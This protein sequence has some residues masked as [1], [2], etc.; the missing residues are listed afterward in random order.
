MRCRRASLLLTLV[1]TPP[2]CAQTAP[3]HL[4]QTRIPP[5][6]QTAPQTMSQNSPRSSYP[7]SAQCVSS[8]NAQ[9]AQPTYIAARQIIVTPQASGSVDRVE[10]WITADGGRSWERVAESRSLGQI[11]YQA[12]DDGT[13]GLL[14]RLINANGAS[15]AEPR[16]GT[17][18]AT[19]VIVDTTP[20]LLQLSAAEPQTPIPATTGAPPTASGARWRL[21][22]SVFDENLG[23]AGVRVFYRQDGQQSWSD[24]GILDVAGA[25][26][27]WTAPH[28]I[29]A[30][31]IDLCVVATDLAGNSRRSELRGVRVPPG[32][33]A[34]PPAGAPAAIRG[35][36]PS[37]RDRLARSSRARRPTSASDP[38]S[39][40]HANGAADA[41]LAASLSVEQQTVSPSADAASPPTAEGMR[42]PVPPQSPNF[43]RAA[44]LRKIAGR[45]IA[46]GETHLATAR[47]EEALRLAPEDVETLLE[48]AAAKAL[49][50]DWSAAAALYQRALAVAPQEP[51][52]LDGLAAA[53][54]ARG[55]YPAAAAALETLVRV[56]PRS[57]D[58]WLHYGDVLHRLGRSAAACNAWTQ[59]RELATDD[60][61]RA[62]ATRR[63]TV[64]A[65]AVRP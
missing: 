56:A 9:L 37:S 38:D 44:A 36:D 35:D 27:E 29:A 28:P 1:L 19:Q 23:P 39:V 62:R 12:P 8:F 46:S 4:T 30:A 34:L 40:R 41:A 25:V 54:T 20:P 26:R 50:R 49:T 32:E 17:P 63:L 48:S 64:S 52:A 45:H 51:R 65:P 6:A 16:A 15:A 60:N 13:Y 2:L 5:A 10:L 47:L 21:T 53:L 42:V 11:A 58:A 61:Q 31:R 57:P 24:G 7:H 14:I 3:P 33:S 18:P 55:E 43:E 22:L 59:A